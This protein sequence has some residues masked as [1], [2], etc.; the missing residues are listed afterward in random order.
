[1]RNLIFYLTISGSKLDSYILI[2]QNCGNMKTT[3]CTKILS[4]VIHY[5]CSSKGMYRCEFEGTELIVT[6]GN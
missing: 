5:Q 3:T 1:M 6:S 2:C 4:N